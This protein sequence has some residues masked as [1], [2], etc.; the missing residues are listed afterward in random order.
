MLQ[1]MGGMLICSW[2]KCTDAQLFTAIVYVRVHKNTKIEVLER[3]INF[4][5]TT[6][7]KLKQNKISL[8]FSRVCPYNVYIISG[9]VDNYV[10]F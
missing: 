1:I 6:G 8:K 5:K 3:K 4:C 7:L 10:K 2:I 9:F